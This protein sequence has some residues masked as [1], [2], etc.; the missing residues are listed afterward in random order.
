VDGQIVEIYA[1]PASCGGGYDQ[2]EVGRKGFI[3]RRFQ[4]IAD[5]PFFNGS[6]THGQIGKL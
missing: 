2:R 4:Q 5:E 1:E 6:W 3:A